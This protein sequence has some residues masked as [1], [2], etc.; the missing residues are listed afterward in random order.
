MTA[1]EARYWRPITV[2]P[3]AHG[4]VA[5]KGDVRPQRF[6]LV[7]G[8][9]GL[10]RWREDERTGTTKE[11]REL[12]DV[13]ARLRHMDQMGVDVQVIY[14]TYLLGSPSPNPEVEL[15]IYRSYNRWLADKTA[16]SN[17]RLRWVVVP[18]MLTMDKAIE[19]L[20]FGKEHGAVGVFKRAVDYGKAISDPYFHPIYEE[21]QRLDMAI[22]T[23]TGGDG[24]GAAGMARPQIGVFTDLVTRNVTKKFPTLRFGVIEA[25]ASWISYVIA[26][27]RAKNAY[28]GSRKRYAENP[29]EDPEEDFMRANRFYVTCQTSEDIPYLVRT[30]CEDNLIV[31]TDYSHGDQASVIDALN[32]IEE[33]GEEEEITTEQARKILVDNPRAFYGL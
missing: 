25:M 21:A 7:D 19:E 4:Q 18:P 13:G 14:P 28:S 29:M 26:D 32:Y 12:L 30:G 16:E 22:C 8:R 17:G 2:D 15:A 27:Q 6:W 1:E 3:A 10:R 31:G 33:L 20:R 9:T 23:H 11:T 5:V 24:G